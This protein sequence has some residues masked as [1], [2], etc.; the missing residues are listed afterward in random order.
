MAGQQSLSVYCYGKTLMWSNCLHLLVESQEIRSLCFDS[1]LLS[2]SLSIHTIE[3]YS[4]AIHY[5]CSKITAASI[6]YET[7]G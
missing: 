2:Y 4:L 6:Y 1:L 5:V 3:I 7:Y